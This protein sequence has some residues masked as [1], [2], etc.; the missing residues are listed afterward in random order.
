VIGRVGVAVVISHTQNAMPATFFIIPVFS[1]GKSVIP[2]GGLGFMIPEIIELI[3]I[4][5]IRQ[6]K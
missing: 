6:R 2:D 5:I 3:P 4:F 1:V